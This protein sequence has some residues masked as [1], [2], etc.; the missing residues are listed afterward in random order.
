M[1]QPKLLIVIASTRPGRI[2]LP[3]AQW[4]HEQAKTHGAFEIQIADL[5]EINLPMMDEPGHP[6]LRQYTK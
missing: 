1:P 6:R 3:V 2:G 5:A 4:F